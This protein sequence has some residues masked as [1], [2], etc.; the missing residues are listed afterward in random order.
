MLLTLPDSLSFLESIR[1]VSGSIY[2]IRGL[3]IR[4]PGI[5]G[6]KHV[7]CAV[8]VTERTRFER[9]MSVTKGFFFWHFVLIH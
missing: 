6:T 5:Y 7:H 3:F 4:I 2:C 8:I 1:P 9:D